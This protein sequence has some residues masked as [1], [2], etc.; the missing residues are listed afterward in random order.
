MLKITNETW[1]RFASNPNCF[2][3][4]FRVGLSLY[5]VMELSV[6]LLCRG[7]QM[8]TLQVGGS[9]FCSGWNQ[10]EELAVSS[11]LGRVPGSQ[12]LKVING[13][14]KATLINYTVQRFGHSMS[15]W[16]K[17]N[18]LFNLEVSTQKYL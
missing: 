12:R 3:D 18:H 16:C 9:G 15:C 5:W 8:E 17:S 14:A 10:R 4:T 2:T 7:E 1:P 13:C 6:A 11:C